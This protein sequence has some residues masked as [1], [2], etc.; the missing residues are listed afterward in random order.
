MTPIET[1]GDDVDPIWET[2]AIRRTDFRSH[3]DGDYVNVFSA[4]PPKSS[5][6]MT[7]ELMRECARKLSDWILTNRDNFGAED[8]FQV[9]IGWPKSVRETNR[10]VIK[11]GGTY[12]ELRMIANGET[13]LTPR[14]CWS[15]GIFEP[16][17]VKL[18][19]NGLVDGL[20]ACPGK[21]FFNEI[22]RHETTDDINPEIR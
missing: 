8:R 2:F 15:G 18:N 16:D 3:W 17:A 4:V 20:L 21:G 13:I 11:T 12:E 5:E 9:I 6:E 7:L 10:Q 14:R 22:P 1:D 19:N